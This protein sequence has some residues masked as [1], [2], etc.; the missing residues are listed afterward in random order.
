MIKC[1]KCKSENIYFSKK[2]NCYICEDCEVRFEQPEE[3]AKKLRLFLSYAHKDSEIARCIR[4]CL[5]N[6]GHEVWIDEEQIKTGDDWREK[7]ADGLYQSNGVVSCLSKAA[8]REEGVCRDELAIAV[9]IRGNNIKT[10]LL[11]KEEIVDPPASVS[12]IQWLDMSD[13]KEKKEEGETAFSVWFEGKMQQLFNSLESEE[14]L[15]YSSDIKTLQNHLDVYYDTSKQE[16]LLRKKFVGRKW[17]TEEIEQWGGQPDRAGQKICLLLGDPGV[18]KSAFSAWYAH[19]SDRVAAALFCSPNRRTFNAPRNVIQT[20]AFLLALK[21]PDYRKALVRLFAEGSRLDLS[22]LNEE[23]LFDRLLRFPLE[24]SIDGNRQSMF[25]LIDGLDEC[26]D[27]EQNVMANLILRYADCLPSWLRFLLVS[28]KVPAVTNMAAKARVIEI[29]SSGEKNRS[30]IRQYFKE[31]LESEFGQEKVQEK[32]LDI[33]AEKSGGI[34]LYS[35]MMVDIIR[36]EGLS[37]D[38]STYPSGLDAVFRF[39]FET[40][41]P[42]LNEYRERWAKVM[43]AIL[44]SPGPM[45]RTEIRRLFGMSNDEVRSFLAKMSVLLRRT[46]DC[47]GEEAYVFSHQFLIQWLKDCEKHPYAIDKEDMIFFLA[48]ELY[49]KYQSAESS[50]PSRYEMLY[51]PWYL[52]QAGLKKQTEKVLFDREWMG[53]LY[54]CVKPVKNRDKKLEIIHQLEQIA[55]MM[56]QSL[57]A[58]DK[59]RLLCAG[60]LYA[61]LASSFSNILYFETALSFYKKSAELQKKVYDSYSF[62]PDIPDSLRFDLA[63]TMGHI[64]SG[65]YLAG[66]YDESREHIDQAIDILGELWRL[67]QNTEAKALM[68][69]LLSRKRDFLD[70]SPGFNAV[71]KKIFEQMITLGEQLV[72]EQPSLT[73]T[74]NLVSAYM[75]AFE[76]HAEDQQWNR[77]VKER[78]NQLC[79]GFDPQ[80][81]DSETA[82]KEL[83]TMMGVKMFLA[84]ADYQEHGQSEK[85]DDLAA[86][87]EKDLERLARLSMSSEELS[88]TN[89]ISL[90]N[91]FSRLS[92]FFSALQKKE[93]AE[94]CIE[95][96]V[97]LA[98]ELKKDYP[99]EN[100]TLIYASSCSSLGKL[101]AGRDAKKALV[102]FEKA[103]GTNYLESE[104]DV[105][106][107]QGKN[108]LGRLLEDVYKQMKELRM[109][110]G[111]TRKAELADAQAEFMSELG[112]ML[113]ELQNE[114]ISEFSFEKEYLQIMKKKNEDREINNWADFCVAAAYALNVALKMASS[115][116]REKAVKYYQ[117]A[118]NVLELEAEY[119]YMDREAEYVLDDDLHLQCKYK[120]ILSDS[121][122]EYHM[123]SILEL[124]LCYRYYL[125][126]ADENE[127]MDLEPKSK[128]LEQFISEVTEQYGTDAVKESIREH[129]S[130]YTDHYFLRIG[131]ESIELIEQLTP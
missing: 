54:E 51:F 119:E 131:K 60:D 22:A 78:L 19:Y 52:E 40:A 129:Y 82:I 2:N 58:D 113:P 55:D 17:L 83:T 5:E 95:Q 71:R 13:W 23:E 105:Q 34:F 117:I 4:D 42:S 41:F 67:P 9:G 91:G 128:E 3:E 27:V 16:A 87:L 121:Y 76:F 97:R 124:A 101:Y 88:V 66:Q 18:G 59:N 110:C 89:R 24:N 68:V 56:E 65:E 94:Y 111:D 118:V 53:E 43:G 69:N 64:A 106:T 109:Q 49:N 20:L 80:G 103:A 81:K 107:L 126:S 127:R 30:D 120:E 98:E 104:S 86:S 90:V 33:L 92:N 47:F 39:W 130:H 1:P 36:K 125:D 25:L 116:E 100:S 50:S 45:P 6:R 75:N 21:L 29:D 15:A 32:D 85:V 26:G 96:G 10:I 35:E 46:E 114:G 7:I 74:M 8:V 72:E 93:Q 115:G 38:F 63:G 14:N 12:H 84:G 123:Y 73:N 48:G 37:G 61:C 62:M 79:K 11:E 108:L 122:L 77:E 31:E 102:F 28:R 99:G 112:W 70:S 57:N 44:Y